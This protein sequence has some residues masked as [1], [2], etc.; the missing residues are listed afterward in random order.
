MSENDSTDLAY[1][2]RAIY[3]GGAGNYGNAWAIN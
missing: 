1:T 2:T 3:V